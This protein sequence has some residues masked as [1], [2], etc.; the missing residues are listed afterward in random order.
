VNHDAILN[1]SEDQ[2]LRIEERASIIAERAAKA[3]RDSH[4]LRSRESFS[5][6]TWT[7]NAGS[8]G[9]STSSSRRFGSTV[10]CHTVTTS[11]I[12]SATFSA[13]AGIG[14]ANGRAPSSAELLN[15]IRGTHTSAASDAIERD[16]EVRRGGLGSGSQ[17][18][19]S[20]PEV[21]V[22][23]ICS[24]LKDRGGSA[25]SVSIIDYFENRVRSED[26]VLFKSLLKQ[27]A[28]LEKRPNGSRWVLRPEYQQ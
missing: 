5:V 14:A 11:T 3:L 15:R 16:L 21:L 27:I 2:K 17:N 19:V 9:A 23:L 24:F 25:D 7:G 4:L 13:G 22:R 18:V 6:P 12:S 28:A 10:N 26:Q 8:A 1:A 20:Q